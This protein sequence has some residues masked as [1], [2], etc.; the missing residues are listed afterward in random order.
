M[1][2][3]IC[4]PKGSDRKF[5]LFSFTGEKIEMTHITETYGMFSLWG[6]KLADGEYW[7]VVDNH[8]GVPEL[9]KIE[10]ANGQAKQDG[11]PVFE[12]LLLDHELK[13]IREEAQQ[14]LASLSLPVLIR[15][16]LRV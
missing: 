1:M 9:H 4:P 15:E 11:K 12:R 16:A 8:H 5:T 6:A 13:Y 7:F 3:L 2:R 10:V 14:K